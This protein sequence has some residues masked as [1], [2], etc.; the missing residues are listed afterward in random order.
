MHTSFDWCFIWITLTLSSR[1][2]LAFHTNPSAEFE[3]ATLSSGCPGVDLDWLAVVP[4]ERTPG[5]DWFI[6]VVY[7]LRLITEVLFTLLASQTPSNEIRMSFWT[8]SKRGG[9]VGGK[10][11]GELGA[12]RVKES[13]GGGGFWKHYAFIPPWSYLY[14]MKR[15]EAERLSKWGQKYVCVCVCVSAGRSEASFRLKQVKK[16][17]FIC[18]RCVC[19]EYKV[20]ISTL[21][22]TACILFMCDCMHRWRSIDWNNNWDS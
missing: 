7:V 19:R 14:W 3:L 12:K 15:K 13:R 4:S 17:A 22:M 18:P 11:E 2:H 1:L 6:V 5:S 16:M 10:S 20:C 8:E 9:G 21:C